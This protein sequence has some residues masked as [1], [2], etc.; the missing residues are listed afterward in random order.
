MQFK[1]EP[2]GLNVLT[3]LSNVVE[4]LG[5]EALDLSMPCRHDPKLVQMKRFSQH[6]F[7]LEVD[8]IDLEEEERKWRREKA[9]R[10]KSQGSGPHS[11]DSIG[12]ARLP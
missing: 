11:L 8:G 12:V 5:G 3:L 4:A 2:K 6:Q 1:G 10:E 7:F 9:E